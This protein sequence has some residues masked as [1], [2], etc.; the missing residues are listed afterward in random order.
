MAII[1]HYLEVYLLL[2]VHLAKSNVISPQRHGMGVHFL[3][4]PMGGF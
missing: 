1:T 4:N 2:K 3:Q